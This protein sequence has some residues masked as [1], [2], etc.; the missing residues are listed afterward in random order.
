M[1]VAFNPL[2]GQ[3]SSMRA[4]RFTT[5]EEKTAKAAE[6][7]QDQM[8]I[9]Q[10]GRQAM[11][12]SEGKPGFEQ[13]CETLETTLRS[14]SKDDFMSMVQEQLGE[15]EL[16]VNWNA[17]V[18][19]DGQLWCKAYFDTYVSQA[20]QFRDTAES[21]IKDY[22]NS[23]YQEA[24]N[25]PLGRNL[26]SQLNFIAAKY[27]CSWSDYFAASIPTNERQWT[28]TQ[29][30]AMLTGTGLRLND[31][32]ALKDIRIPTA[33]ETAKIARQAADDR[34]NKLIR[35]GEEASEISG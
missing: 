23:A 21:A 10:E 24:L 28:Y 31:P 18:D 3:I 22:Y 19:P 17:A 13:F 33:E 26:S 27:Q 5:P 8:D 6:Q 4:A 14:M 12:E 29:V 34:I 30:R 7:S 11:S 16:K 2:M 35:Q 32:F 25:S 9:S 20:V 1:D 15:Q